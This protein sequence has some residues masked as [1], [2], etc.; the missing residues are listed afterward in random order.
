F[1][2]L[3]T[4]VVRAAIPQPP[5]AELPKA[6]GHPIDG[7]AMHCQDGGG[8]PGGAAVVQIDNDQETQALSGLM[9]LTQLLEQS[10]LDAGAKFRENRRH[11]NSLLGACGP[12]VVADRE[13]PFSFSHVFSGNWRAAESRTVI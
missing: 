5:G 4:A 3:G 9:T 2:Q 6:L 11:G 8:V 7:G 1:V 10:L 13:F 12:G